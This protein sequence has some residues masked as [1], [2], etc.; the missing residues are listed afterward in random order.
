MTAWYTLILVA[1]EIPLQFH[2]FLLSQPK[3]ALAFASLVFSSSSMMRV[4]PRYVNFSPTF[5]CCS[6]IVMLGL[7]WFSRH[8]QV[9]Y[10]YL[11]CA[12]G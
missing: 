3:A 6:L 10:F 11:L 4:L 8:W 9:H 1:S 2:T 5:S 12:D 7:T